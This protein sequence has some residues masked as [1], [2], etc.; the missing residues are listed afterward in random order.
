MPSQMLRT[1]GMFLSEQERKLS[2]L[3]TTL[4]PHSID[5][6]DDDIQLFNY[7]P[8]LYL[9]GFIVVRD[10][11]QHYYMYNFIFLLCT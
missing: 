9:Q 8:N 11:V 1:L 3:T 6:D 2:R 4:P 5:E 10:I 7:E